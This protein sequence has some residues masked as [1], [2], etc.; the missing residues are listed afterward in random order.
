MNKQTNFVIDKIL[1]TKSKSVLN[2]GYRHDS[3]TTIQKFC[4]LNDIEWN[5][6]EIWKENCDF[7]K[8]N[9]ICQNVFNEDV[10]NIKNINKKFDA[11]IWLHGPE[12]VKWSDFLAFRQDLEDCSNKIILY[13]APEGEYPQE[14]LYGNPFEQ[15]VETLF[16][17]QFSEIGYETNNFINF[18]EKTFSAWK[19]FNQE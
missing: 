19:T 9:N 7:L 18:G 14:S 1:E 16:E 5:V 10:K 11:I 13:Q 2:V 15:H 3:D 6:I 4:D 17:K 12:H 8:Q